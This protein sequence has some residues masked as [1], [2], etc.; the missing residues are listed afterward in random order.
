LSGQITLW[1]AEKKKTNPSL[2]ICLLPFIYTNWSR[3][4]KWHQ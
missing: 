2:I 4:N 1:M 3:C